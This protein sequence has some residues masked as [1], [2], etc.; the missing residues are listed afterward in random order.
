MKAQRKTSKG[1]SP[2]M[3]SAAKGI[4]TSALSRYGQV[5]LTLLCAFV[6][7]QSACVLVLIPNTHAYAFDVTEGRET[8]QLSVTSVSCGLPGLQQT[9]GAN[10]SDSLDQALQLARLCPLQISAT[11]NPSSIQAG[12]DCGMDWMCG[13]DPCLCGSADEWGGCSCNGLQ[14]EFPVVGFTSSDE[15]VVRVVEFAG[16][17]WLVP[18]G[19][20]EATVQVNTSLRYHDPQDFSFTVQVDSLQYADMLLIGV[21]VLIIALIVL[22]VALVR[23]P[24]KSTKA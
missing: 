24:R 12:I 1:F 15:S 4:I 5:K 20:G 6:V 19:V 2:N 10:E 7:V 9:L 21:S 14:E 22:V 11:C 18:T 17:S 8:P 13:I 23:K 3:I 16:S